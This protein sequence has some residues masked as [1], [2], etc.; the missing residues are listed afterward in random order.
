MPVAGI[1]VFC[2]FPHNLHVATFSPL[3]PQ[4]ASLVTTASPNWHPAGI[5]VYHVS[6]SQSAHPYFPTP[7]TVHVASFNVANNSGVWFS[8]SNSSPTVSFS[9]PHN[10]HFSNLYD[11]A[12]QVAA[13]SSTTS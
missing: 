1:S 10:L 4:V 2:S 13:F 7:A 12:A 5:D 11:P 9:S 6:T 3:A 8:G